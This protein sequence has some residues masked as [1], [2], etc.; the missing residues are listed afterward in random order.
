MREAVACV[1]CVPEDVELIF[2]VEGSGEE[3]KNAGDA[4]GHGGSEEDDDDSLRRVRF[5]NKMRVSSNV[6]IHTSSR[7]WRGKKIIERTGR[8]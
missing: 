6:I 3:A 7:S 1:W 5:K 2:E 4:F 8:W